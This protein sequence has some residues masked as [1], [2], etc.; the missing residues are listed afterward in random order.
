MGTVLYRSGVC[1]IGL[2]CSKP[3]AQVSL[4]I[5]DLGTYPHP[6]QKET[7]N[8]SA[9]RFWITDGR[10]LTKW[11]NIW[12]SVMVLHIKSTTELALIKFLQDGFQNNSQEST[13]TTMWQSARAFLTAFIMKGMLLGFFETH[14]HWRRDVD[15]PLRAREQTPEQGVET[16]D[17]TSQK[18]VLKSTI[19]QT[20]DVHTFLGLTRSNFG[21]LS[22][23]GHNGKQCTLLWNVAEPVE[24]S[25]LMEMPRATVKRLFHDNAHPHMLWKPSSNW[26]LWCWSILCT[27]LTWPFQKFTCLVHSKTL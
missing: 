7:L 21:T 12:T 20:S 19:G 3:V 18:E 26:N 24:T 10:L 16:S 2:P 8:E 22:R 5:N 25:Y 14:C 9:P 23:G 17:I 15:P 11:H 13:S 1:M 27:V 6:Q 4:F